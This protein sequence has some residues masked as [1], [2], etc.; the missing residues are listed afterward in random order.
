MNWFNK[1]PGFQ[2]SAAGLEWKIWR[3]LPLVLL[4]GT[5]LPLL[6]LGL[7]HLGLND[8]TTELSQRQ[9]LLADYITVAVVVL[10][11]TSVFTVGIG[12]V[13]VMIM[14]GPAYVADGFEV[15]HS[16]QPRV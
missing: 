5:V 4:T 15:S 12:C 3:K 1:L 8:A 9:L 13:I 6:G 10:H 7:V 14:K 2:R 11:W 16:D